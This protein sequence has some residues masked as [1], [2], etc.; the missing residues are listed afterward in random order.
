VL[1]LIAGLVQHVPER[2]GDQL[3]MRIEALGLGLGKGG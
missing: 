3:Q 1:Q 2:Q